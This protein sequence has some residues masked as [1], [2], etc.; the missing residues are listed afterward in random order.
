MSYPPTPTQ[1]SSGTTGATGVAQ[2]NT[3]QQG[4]NV[5]TSGGVF[6]QQNQYT[7]GQQGLQ[8]GLNSA[9][10]GV[11]AG[12]GIPGANSEI[13]EQM[14][15]YT[16]YYNEY[17]APQ[18]AAQGGGG[19]PAIASGLSLGLE[20]LQSN[21]ANNQYNT[22]ASTFNNALGT[23]TTAAYNAVGSSGLNANNQATVSQ[24][25]TNS[26]TG[27]SNAASWQSNTNPTAAT[28]TGLANWAQLLGNYFTGP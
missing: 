11:L 17:V 21:L 18:Q 2:T 3:Q 24:T 5:S 16:D 10:G 20:Q 15:A 23:G 13:P 12:N 6:N 19:S 22:N 1:Y 26:L 28:T 8:Q 27:T 25:G 7:Q 9:I 4:S 14:K